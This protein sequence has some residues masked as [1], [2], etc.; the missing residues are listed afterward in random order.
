M[1][2]SDDTPRAKPSRPG[3]LGDRDVHKPKHPRPDTHG[4]QSAVPVPVNDVDSAAVEAPEQKLRIRKNR[5]THDN[6]IKALARLDAQDDVLDLIKESVKR[7]EALE[8][9]KAIAK[10]QGAADRSKTKQTLIRTA[11]GGLGAI[12]GYLAHLLGW[13]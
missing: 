1:A 2:D 10:V 9:S 12:V 6:A 11:I 3:T 13:L 8:T 7:I 4:H 5:D